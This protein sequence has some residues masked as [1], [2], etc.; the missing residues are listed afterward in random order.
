VHTAPVRTIVHVVRSGATVRAACLALAAAIGLGAIGLGAV[1]LTGIGVPVAHAAD[2]FAETGFTTYTLEPA[3]GR[4]A[5]KVTL[6]ITNNTPDTTE[7]YTC[8]KYREDWFWGTVPYTDTCYRTTH[9][10]RDTASIWVER[11]AGKVKATSGGKK[12][13]VETGQKGDAHR[14]QT[15]RFP[16]LFYGKS[17][18]LTITYNLRGG[19]PRSDTFTRTLRAYASFCV[20]ANG[21]DRGE[22]TVRLPSGFKVDTSGEALRGKTDGGTRVFTSGAVKDTA[23]WYA[24][25]S[26]TNEDGYTTESMTAPDGR[27]VRLLSWPEDP[28]WTRGVRSEVTAGLPE[29]RRIVG[30]NMEG[31]DA[32]V[33]KEASTGNEYAGFYDRKSN[34]ITVGED[35][36]QPSLVAHE[37]AHVWF[38]GSVFAETWM[39]EG[40]A[41]WAGREAS[42]ALGPCGR[43]EAAPSSI[44]LGDWQYLAPR[45]TAQERVAVEAQYDAACYIVTQVAQAAGD[46]R[47]TTVTA[48]LLGRADPYTTGAGAGSGPTATAAGTR[49]TKVA[50]WRDWLDAADELGLRPAGASETLASDLL[51]EFGVTSDDGLLAKR[52]SARRAYQELLATVVGWQVPPVVRTPL[53]EWHFDD[54]Q[55][56]IDAAGATWD[57][58]GEVD[59]VLAG[60][61][62]RNGPA[63][64]AW[65]AATSLADLEASGEIARR[66]LVAARDI[67]DVRVLLDQKLD[68]VQQ[69][70]MLGTV[71]PSLDSAVAAVR[72]G[73]ADGA[74]AVTLSVRSMLGGLRAQGEQRIVL[75]VAVAILVLALVVVL[76]VW[77]VQV[78]SR[79]RRLA[80]AASGV[81]LGG[82]LAR[83]SDPLPVRATSPFD[84]DTTTT[85]VE[86]DGVAGPMPAWASPSID[87]SPTM[88][89]PD[90][91][92]PRPL[93][94]TMPPPTLPPTTM[95]PQPPPPPAPTR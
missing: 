58:T 29:L 89:V 73:D 7:P 81:P 57:L 14:L 38:N 11:E 68:I 41:E 54:A 65:E 12:L 24:C 2:G 10:Y 56:A 45:A 86:L 53:A 36:T 78:S 66:Q 79:R 80:R 91:P 9:W 5:V 8:T 77:R 64:A 59:S 16:K 90:V 76:A 85:V 31:T 40:Y 39:S 33:V 92:V 62:A 46:D 43:P 69:V 50:T 82:V 60:V 21:A 63:A 3:K 49:A 6:K 13:A 32:L 84:Q 34:T 48:A 25:L 95:P 4:L 28:A 15:I 74:A 19:P 88:A 27:T 94:P 26:G 67:A 37:L 17:R 72:A 87:D 55:A 23:S 75:S 83:P 51:L 20:I 1:G 52:T 47:M 93:P 61:D 22:V 30:A 71:M 70:G 42:A 44:R 18:T 35:Y